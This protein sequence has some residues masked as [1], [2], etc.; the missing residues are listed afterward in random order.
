MVLCAQSIPA[1]M[2]RTAVPTRWL[3]WSKPAVCRSVK[4]VCVTVKKEGGKGRLSANPGM[5]LMSSI[6]KTTATVGARQIGE[7]AR[8]QGCGKLLTQLIPHLTE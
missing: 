8:D 5:P 1:F 2:L 6:T 3:D 7:A 4:P